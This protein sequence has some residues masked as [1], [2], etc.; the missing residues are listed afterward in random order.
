MVRRSAA[1]PAPPAGSIPPGDGARVIDGVLSFEHPQVRVAV[2]RAEAGCDVL[3]MIAGPVAVQ[4][5]ITPDAA[6]ELSAQLQ[7][8]AQL[9]RHPGTAPGEAPPQGEAAT[10]APPT[11]AAPVAGLSHCAWPGA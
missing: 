8:F 4:L 6:D 9:A 1:W 3:L 11:P 7:R 5:R 10:L 2:R